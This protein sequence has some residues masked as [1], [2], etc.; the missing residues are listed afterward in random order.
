MYSDTE[1]AAAGAA[2]AGTGSAGDSVFGTCR[3][4]CTATFALMAWGYGN[5]AGPAEQCNPAVYITKQVLAC[6]L[7][8]RCVTAKVGRS[9]WRRLMQRSGRGSGILGCTSHLGATISKR[10][11]MQG[12]EP[13][14]ARAWRGLN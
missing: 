13:A 4:S 2:G 12:Q 3:G 6:R 8:T 5:A 7:T 9:F 14:S 10:E 11:Q 1:A